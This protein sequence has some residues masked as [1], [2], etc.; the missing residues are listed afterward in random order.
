MGHPVI[1]FEIHGHDP[2][3]LHDFYRNV[4]GWTIDADNPMS[5]GFVQTG[6][7]EG[8]QG[9]IAT[10]QGTRGVTVYLGTDDVQAT[11]DRAVEAGAEVVMPVGGIP[12][13][14]QLAQFRDPEGNWIG[15]SK[16][17]RDPEGNWIER[18]KNPANEQS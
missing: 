1:W 2:T 16:D 12:G 17:L 4:F 7:G 3:R 5:Y 14:V 13:V 18:V 9:A 11:L 10:G 8:I 6:S 15:L